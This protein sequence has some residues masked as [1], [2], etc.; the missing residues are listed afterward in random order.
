[1]TGVGPLTYWISAFVFDYFLLFLVVCVMITCFPI[2]QSY[3]IF[4]THGGAGVAFVI[5]MVYGLSA[6]I[7]SYLFSLYARTVAGGVALVA[8]IHIISGVVFG[9]IV[10]FL[11]I[12]GTSQ[13][14][15]LDTAARFRWA[16]R[17]FP[18]FGATMSTMR[19]IEI[20]SKNGRCNLLSDEAK[21][22]L[23]NPK[24]INLPPSL[25][26]CCA[27]CKKL[28][29]SCFKPITY[30]SW[31]HK[32]EALLGPATTKDMVELP[33]I[34]QELFFML[35]MALIYLTVLML[36]EYRIVQRFFEM[37]CQSKTTVFP[38]TVRDDDVMAEANRVEEMVKN[39]NVNEDALVVKKLCKSYGSFAAVSN[40]FFGVHHGE[41]FG[42][43]GVNG[44]GKT[45]TFR[46]LTGDETRS[47]GNVYAFMKSL[48]EDRIEFLSNI[49]YCPQFDGIVGVLSGKQML[50]LFGRL[51]GV[52]AMLANVQ[53]EKYSGG[54]KRRLGVAMAM[55]GEPQILLLDEPTSGVDPVSKLQFWNI[56]DSVRDAG[57]SI[58]LT[59]HSMEECE[60]LCSRLGIMVNGQLQCIGGVQHLKHKF[61]QGYTLSIKLKL[62]CPHTEEQ[63]LDTLKKE[64]DEKFYPCTLKD[65]HQ[66]VF[67]YQLHNTALEWDVVFKTME[68]LKQSYSE[69]IEDYSLNET[70]LEEVFLAFARNQTPNHINVENMEVRGTTQQPQRR[71]ARSGAVTVTCDEPVAGPSRL[72]QLQQLFPAKGYRKEVVNVAVEDTD[73]P[74]DLGPPEAVGVSDPLP[75]SRSLSVQQPQ[76][77]PPASQ[78][79]KWTN[80][81][82]YLMKEALPFVVRQ[83][84]AQTFLNPIDP[85]ELEHSD[86]FDFIKHPMDLTTIRQRLRNQFYKSASECVSD[87]QRIVCNVHVYNGHES[88]AFDDAELLENI[89]MESLVKMPQPEVELPVP[90][91][92]GPRKRK[93]CSTRSED[94]S[95]GN[96]ILPRVEKL[97][98]KAVESLKPEGPRRRRRA[99][100][101]SD[102]DAS[103]DSDDE[104]LSFAELRRLKQVQFLSRQLENTATQLRLV[105]TED[106]GMVEEVYACVDRQIK[107]AEKQKEWLAIDTM[108]KFAH[109]LRKEKDHHDSDFD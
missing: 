45:T 27:N 106:D 104:A 76:V 93:R 10:Y 92:G 44:A 36:L 66:N 22:F 17:L 101:A 18:T 26:E 88:Q 49:G 16:G 62:H 80:Q 37:I 42:L 8:L 87:F 14:G 21:D 63:N 53:C 90:L 64:I 57:Q 59:S 25:R 13:A 91:R 94:R 78:K 96:I 4:T 48:D 72:S 74:P 70:S 11:E 60:A 35:I 65:I 109:K 47:A 20:A 77:K 81:L 54:M 40:L 105:C 38:N 1:M 69:L 102:S 34:A 103:T 55:I 24:S 33:G 5:L 56:L 2:F 32:R 43:L 79:R 61:A 50:Q 6:I 83:K 95:A 58:I 28:G 107:L 108:K 30:I 31:I 19:Y 9:Y 29:V 98:K 7:Y 15:L 86:Y 82:N 41:C 51:R 89:F 71:F 84:A 23:C 85:V 67:Q 99:Q 46:I 75:R 39:G 68:D 12:I 100:K 97:V 52:L 3:G 73:S